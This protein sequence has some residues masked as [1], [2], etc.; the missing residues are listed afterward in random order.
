MS[1]VERYRKRSRSGGNDDRRD[2]WNDN[3]DTRSAASKCK[4]VSSDILIVEREDL[5]SIVKQ[6][7]L[8]LKDLIER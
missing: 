7:Q 2:S 8:V 6:Q 1:W 3:F 5:T 4:K